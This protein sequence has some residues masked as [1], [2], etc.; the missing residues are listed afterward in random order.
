MLEFIASII[1]G[2]AM[3]FAFEVIGVESHTAF[4]LGFFIIFLLVAVP[5][6]ETVKKER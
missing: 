1:F 5:V 2:I 4:L 3:I 6:I